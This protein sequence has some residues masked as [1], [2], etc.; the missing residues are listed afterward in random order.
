MNRAVCLLSGGLDSTVTLYA[1]RR[2]GFEPVALSIEYGQRHY[3]EI[4]LAQ[5]MTRSLGLKHYFASLSMPWKG[6]ALL[7]E[8]APLPK[9]RDAATI[10]GG[11]IPATYV[12]GR[13]SVFLAMAIS[14]AEIVQ[15][16][17]VFIGVNALDYS[18]YPDCR[19]E[20]LQAFAD[21]VNLGTRAGIEGKRIE[22]K[23]PLIRLSKK[24]IVLLGQKLGVPFE[25]T[26]SCYEGSDKPCGECD[27][28]LLRAK[29]FAEAGFADPL[30]SYE[31]PSD[32]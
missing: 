16:G 17:T 13:N 27:S 5:N 10:S 25:R 11:G 28:C 1:A 2:E 15:A 18:G 22:I 19:P 32:R 3:K 24:E 7:D 6:S 30:L 23:A 4:S 14:C 20:Y 26:W 9:H 12:P 29:G 8:K 21:A 31:T